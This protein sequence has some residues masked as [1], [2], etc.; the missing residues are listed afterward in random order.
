MMILDIFHAFISDIQESRLEFARAVGADR[1]VHVSNEVEVA[2]LRSSH[3]PDVSFDCVL[4]CCGVESGVK[5]GLTLA[6][7]S[8]V[9]VTVGRGPYEVNINVGE[10][11]R[12]EL[13]IKGLFRY[14]NW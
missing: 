8:A 1:T 4:D 10:V 9:L 12:K 6:A 5:L 13:V 11:T 7:P 2:K 3:P 14:A